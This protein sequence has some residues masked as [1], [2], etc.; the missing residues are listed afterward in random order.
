MV[1][2]RCGVVFAWLALAA[3]C[4]RHADEAPCSAVAARLLVVAR[5][6]LDAAKASPELI[7]QVSPQLPALRDAV[8]EACSRGDWPL[9]VRTCMITAA[10]GASLAA[11]QSG[12]TAEQR[13]A[14]AR[15]SATR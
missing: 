10:D 14:L 5:A 1:I 13:Q 9:S 6:E 3:G 12:L 15:A 11:C 2:V 4:R 8:D 7:N